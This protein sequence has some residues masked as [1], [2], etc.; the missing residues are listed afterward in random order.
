MEI[1][2]FYDGFKKQIDTKN[3]INQS[4]NSFNEI[5]GLSFLKNYKYTIDGNML[6][7]SSFESIISI[8][9]FWSHN[10]FKPIFSNL[11]FQIFFPK[12]AQ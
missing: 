1:L 8:P 7:V 6:H 2:H 11:F 3:I 4:N 9:L 12:K 5:D 10:L